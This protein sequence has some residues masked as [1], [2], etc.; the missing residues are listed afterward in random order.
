MSNTVT[1]HTDPA[2]LVY[3]A[4]LD[5]D[6]PFTAVHIAPGASVI[7]RDPAHLT[8][9]S[10][11]FA[12]AAARQSTAMDAHRASATPAAVVEVTA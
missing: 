7:S 9:L 4:L 12:E 6:G 8:R 1:I 5:A 10:T 2:D 3:V 11:L